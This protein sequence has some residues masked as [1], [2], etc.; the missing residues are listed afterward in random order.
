MKKVGDRRY[1]P[2]DDEQ[3]DDSDHR[4]QNIQLRARQLGDSCS[5]S[6]L[7]LDLSGVLIT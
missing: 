7:L 4:L 1:S 2:T 6:R 5:Y 3:R